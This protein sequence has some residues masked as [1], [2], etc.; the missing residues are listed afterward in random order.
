MNEELKP[1]GWNQL[2]ALCRE[3]VDAEGERS[4]ER[5]GELE[6]RGSRNI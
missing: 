3:Q 5:R 6:G 1:S 4:E 2:T